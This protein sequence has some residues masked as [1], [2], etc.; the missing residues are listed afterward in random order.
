MTDHKKLDPVEVSDAIRHPVDMLATYEDTISGFQGV[1]TSIGYTFTKGIAVALTRK[2]TQPHDKGETHIFRLQQ[3]APVD[4]SRLKYDMLPEHQIEFL[5]KYTDTITGFTGLATYIT[6][7]ANKCVQVD[8]A[9]GDTT[10][11][12]VDHFCDIQN[13]KPVEPESTKPITATSNTHP[14]AARPAANSLKI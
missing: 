14:G 3:L 8:L 5:K 9:T 1:V 6:Y 11:K 12:P 4:G 10:N 13:I 2:G 7:S